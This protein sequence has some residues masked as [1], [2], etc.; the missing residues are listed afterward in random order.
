[1]RK[2]GILMHITSLPG[3]CGIGTMGKSA[4]DFVDFLA[5]AGQRSWQILPLTPT[6]YGDSPYQSCSAYAGNP[7]LI[8]FDLLVADG[9]LEKAD[10]ESIDWADS[11]TRV[12]YGKQYNNKNA[13]LRKAYANFQGS[14]AFDA[15]QEENAAWLPD[16][17]LFMALKGEN[18]S[19]AWYTWEE[20]LKFR[21]ARALNAARKR[22]ANEIRFY[23]FVQF[24]FYKQWSALR[25]YANGKDIEIIGDVPIYVPYD[26]V[27]V[28]CEPKLFQLDKDLTPTA[29]AGC[30]PDAF[31]ADGQLWGNPLYNWKKIAKDGYGWWL[32][33]LGAA[34]KL[35]DVVR[36]DHFRGF[37][38]YWSVPYGDTTAKNG[39]WI[40]GPDMDFVNALKTG[41][42]ELKFIAEDLGTLTQA[43]LDLRDNS[44]YPGMKVLGF[45]FDSREPS[46]YLPYCFPANSVCYTGT[47]DNMTTLQWFQT[48]SKDAIDYVCEY[49][50]LDEVTGLLGLEEM[51]W[52]LI[53]TAMAS[54]SDLTV[55][56]MQ[57]YLTLGGESRMNFP[58]TMTNANWTWRAEPGFASADLA[59]RIR[60]MTKL[61]GRLA[62]EP[63]AEAEETAAE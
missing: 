17:C 44:G 5:D 24:L 52:G 30:P 38:A 4:F 23:A 16:F 35:Y 22:L 20:E 49:M 54:V 7:Y 25:A 36:L 56:Q 18:N 48:A 6:G 55:I 11:E 47:H 8:D 2:S 39:Q 19:A 28:W 42:P 29:I 53:R 3:S 27:E 51:V 37:E 63:K 13:V 21:K 46:E 62:P 50:G 57:D 33:R 58:G 45:A 12:D 9:L 40:K 60:A 41:L 14:A 10:F 34:G 15:F 61:Y 1:M 26:S 59:K 32:R 31:S 43:V